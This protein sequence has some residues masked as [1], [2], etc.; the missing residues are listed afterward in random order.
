MPEN[1]A[2][3]LVLLDF[4]GTLLEGDIFA[5]FLKLRL[6]SLRMKIRALRAVPFLLAYKLGLMSNSR[7]KEAVFKV[8]FKGESESYFRS[9]VAAFWQKRGTQLNPSIHP[10]I[11][12]YKKEGA[13]LCI[14][15]A[16]FSLLLEAFCERHPEFKQIAT[17]VAV[18]NGKIT[19]AFDSPNCHGPEKVKRIEAIYG[20]VRDQYQSVHAYGD[21]QG[22]IP[23]LQWAD[24][25][26]LLQ[27]GAWHK[28]D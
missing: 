7:S 3:T 5:A 22:D 19:G 16:N 2:R 24:E 6:K 11:E 26:Y 17:Q 20:Q 21:T 25:G 15:S 28:I 4:D 14:V 1:K 18:Q 13:E 8:L 27:N 10:K 23:M 9:E 12:A